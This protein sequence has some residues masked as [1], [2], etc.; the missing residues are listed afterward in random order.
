MENENL[1]KIIIKWFWMR[2]SHMMWRN[3]Y[4]RTWMQEY[5]E[6]L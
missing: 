3:G 2:I 4:G 1:K 6:H 5:I